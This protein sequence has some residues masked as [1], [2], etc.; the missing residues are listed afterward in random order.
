[1]SY[2]LVNG[3]TTEEQWLD[4]LLGAIGPGTT[5]MATSRCSPFRPAGMAVGDVLIHRV[6]GSPACEL[7]ALGVVVK[8]AHPSG[9]ERWPWQIGRQ[10]L[11]VCPTLA[12]APKA[13]DAGVVAKGLRVTKRLS[14]E[15]DAPQ[16]R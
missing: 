12:A 4:R 8:A 2:W 13:G 10:L 11:Y 1:M 3:G 7:I 14:P 5:S 15:R 6:V 16:K 9:D